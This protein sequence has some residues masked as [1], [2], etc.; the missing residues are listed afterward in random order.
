MAV[1]APAV[2]PYDPLAANPIDKFLPPLSSGHI[3]GTDE[4]GRDILSRLIYGAR[5]ALFLAVVPTLI[6][7]VVGGL[8]GLLA[9]YCGGVVDA[10]I[11]R[12]F[13]VM[14]AFPGILLAL[15]ISAALGAGFGS[16]L[17]AMVVVAIP[18][19]GRLVR[20][21]VLTVKENLYVEAARTLGLS[22][23]KIALRHVLPNLRAPII[24][25]TAMQT[26]NNVILGASLS[27]LGLGAQPPTPDWGAMLDGGKSAMLNAPHVATIA[28]LA[29]VY[30]TI[31]FN[32]VGDAV[33]DRFDPSSTNR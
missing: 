2:A 8:I 5:I 13:D 20:G 24:V 32:L 33:R 22:N 14:F 6:A 1:F 12:V 4:L 30:L 18:E 17:T 27:F 9:G 31:C 21:C 15:G 7:L 11:M 29:I 16:M 10:V 23:I 19:F 3:L 28:G 26:G 25:M